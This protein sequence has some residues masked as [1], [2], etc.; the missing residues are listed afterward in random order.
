MEEKKFIAISEDEY[1]SFKHGE[2]EREIENLKEKIEEL[3][4]EKEEIAKAKGVILD[5][6]PYCG[7]TKMKLISNENFENEILE[8]IKN[9]EFKHVVNDYIFCN[10]MG[11]YKEKD[12]VQIGDTYY[13]K[14]EWCEKIKDN[15][16]LL[17]RQVKSLEE[18][19]DRLQIEVEILDRKIDVDNDGCHLDR[20]SSILR[21]II[22]KFSKQ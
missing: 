9:T 19:R 22:D 20:D 10:H 6:I 14:N 11:F 8:A 17:S 7:A 12:Y 4:K 18:K 15:L 2:Y 1:N 5:I 16:S 3:K 13:Y 21:R